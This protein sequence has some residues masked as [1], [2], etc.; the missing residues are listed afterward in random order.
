MRTH[1]VDKLLEQHCYKSAAGLLQLVRFYVCT[2]K[3][4]RP[5]KSSPDMQCEQHMDSLC[6]YHSEFGFIIL[7]PVGSGK[8][9]LAVNMAL[10]S[11][12]PL[13]KMCSP[14]SMTGFSEQAKCNAIKKV[15]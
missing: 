10:A 11:E 3:I 7:G 5:E 6:Q 13:I 2:L 4:F 15:N 1:P 9:A 12:F 8:T 14:E